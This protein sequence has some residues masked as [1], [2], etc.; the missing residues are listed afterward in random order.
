[1]DVALVSS[2]LWDNALSNSL[3]YVSDFSSNL[4]MEEFVDP[5]VVGKSS[6]LL[7]QRFKVRN[8]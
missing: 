6:D 8:F 4:K 3:S 7:S 2:I 5:F 1:M